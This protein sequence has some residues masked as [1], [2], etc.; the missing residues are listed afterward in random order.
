MENLE[1]ERK[2]IRYKLIFILILAAFVDFIITLALWLFD[3]FLAIIGGLLAGLWIY[4]WFKFKFFAKFEL[5]LKDRLRDEIIKE[6]NLNKVD[7]N[8]PSINSHFNH[9]VSSVSEF[10]LFSLSGF[11]VRDICVKSTDEMLFYGILISGKISKNIEPK[12]SLLGY[13]SS[14]FIDDGYLSLYI[15]TDADTIVANLKT[16][17]NIS[18]KSAMDNI[19]EIIKIINQLD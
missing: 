19:K 7:D 12:E 2:S 14:Y 10:G 13:K 16:P 3:P 1:K 8:L 9:I 18:Y 4:F 15:H 17:L 5:G 6:L 11:S